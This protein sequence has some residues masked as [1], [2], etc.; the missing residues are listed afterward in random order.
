MLTIDQVKTGYQA[1]A[2]VL[3]AIGTLSFAISHLPLP[4]VWAERFARFAAYTSQR[5]SVNQRPVDP[6]AK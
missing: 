2:D 5:F 3:A 6:G 1:F 4:P